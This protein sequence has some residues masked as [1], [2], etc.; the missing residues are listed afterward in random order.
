MKFWSVTCKQ[1]HQGKGR[2]QPIVFA[3][4]ANTSVDAMDHA[5]AMP[6]VKHECMIL[7]CEE[8]SFQRYCE[9]RQV[10]AYRRREI[11]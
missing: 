6:G 4:A 1:G 5:K 10:S 2:Y 8:I 9:L 11:S 3:I 7:S